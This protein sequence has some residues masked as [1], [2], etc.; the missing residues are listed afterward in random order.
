MKKVTV[1]QKPACTTCRQLMRILSEKEIHFNAVDYY[2]HPFTKPVLK[3]LL[4]KMNVPIS[5]IL[6]KSDRI[7][8]EL[9]LSHKHYSEDELLDLAIVHPDLIQRPIVEIGDRAILARPP[10]KVLELF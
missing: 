1:Y 3:A 7:Y 9:D 8:K 10:E 2:I 4:V 5:Q 6:R